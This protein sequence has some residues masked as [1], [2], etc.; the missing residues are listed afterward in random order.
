[1][2]KWKKKIKFKEILLIKIIMSPLSL[3]LK[4]LRIGKFGR[5]NE[6]KPCQKELVDYFRALRRVGENGVVPYKIGQAIANCMD[7]L[8]SF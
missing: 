2:F 3:S 8:V 4:Q 6:I 5:R 7:T 1:M